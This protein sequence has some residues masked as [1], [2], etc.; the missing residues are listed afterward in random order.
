MWARAGL[1][2]CDVRGSVGDAVSLLSRVCAT[3][4]ASAAAATAASPSLPP[5]LRL[6]SCAV[7]LDAVRLLWRP[8]SASA[9]SGSEPGGL[10]QLALG[11][12][13]M[14]TDWD[15]HS[16]QLSGVALTLS[17]LRTESEEF[18]FDTNANE[19]PEES[20]DGPSH[21]A[22][23]APSPPEPEVAIQPV[24]LSSSPVPSVPPVPTPCTPQRG[25]ILQGEEPE[26]ETEDR[27][28]SL[29][30]PDAPILEPEPLTWSDEEAPTEAEPEARRDKTVRS[31]PPVTRPAPP[32]PQRPPPPS[33]SL[34]VRLA[35]R[36]Q[37]TS[38]GWAP[39][40]VSLGGCEGVP[41]S[42][43]LRIDPTVLH[44]LARLLVAESSAVQ[45]ACVRAP[46]LLFCLLPLAQAA[47]ADTAL[48]WAHRT[49]NEPPP[50]VQLGR[51]VRHRTPATPEMASNSELA[52]GVDA[53]AAL[54][55]L[56]RSGELWHLRPGTHQ[57]TGASVTLSWK[58]LLVRHSRTD[59]FAQMF[60]LQRA[61]GGCAVAQRLHPASV[62][63]RPHAFALSIVGHADA[64]VFAA[65]CEAECDAWL[66]AAEAAAG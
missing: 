27:D 2:G 57:W 25:V 66:Q 9:E 8:L 13:R 33:G 22:P 55:V 62:G 26:E 58:V 43:S 42:D 54:K 41:W 20:G 31:S 11:R 53:A 65:S 63:G 45:A 3:P 48:A 49:A 4:V 15:Q 46:W 21:E 39:H 5:S 64:L 6:A 10:P 52:P 30:N 17:G 44:A 23:A 61:P 18:V 14:C 50:V 38:H 1:A 28:D 29:H 35:V 24:L 36:L 47:G 56:P 19:A 60:E 16:A 12:L 7:S 40:S 59:A 34:G 51:D 37:K 32:L